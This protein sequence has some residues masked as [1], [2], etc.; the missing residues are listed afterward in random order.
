MVAYAL[1]LKTSWFVVPEPVSCGDQNQNQFRKRS[2]LGHG[3][4]AMSHACWRKL[5]HPVDFHGYSLNDRCFAGSPF[6]FEAP[7]PERLALFCSPKRRQKFTQDLDIGCNRKA[8]HGR[9][10]SASSNPF[11]PH[12]FSECPAG[13]RQCCCRRVWSVTQPKCCFLQVQWSDQRHKQEDKTQQR[14]KDVEVELLDTYW[15]PA[16]C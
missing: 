14:G 15:F 12:L 6:T 5:V 3:P 8:W 1:C 7:T 16:D 2:A 4:R 13:E 9:W 11:Q 10:T